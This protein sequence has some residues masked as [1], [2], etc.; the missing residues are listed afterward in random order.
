MLKKMWN[1]IRSRI[2]NRNYEN[3]SRLDQPNGFV[4][5]QAILN[6]FR[7]GL[8][9]MNKVG[10]GI[11]AAYNM[12]RLTGQPT[13]MSELILEF[14]TNLTETIPFGFFGINPFSMKKFF[15]A[16]NISYCI[17]SG[18]NIEKCREEGGV[19]IFAFWIDAKNPFKGAHYV[20][21]HF[22]NG[23][24]EVYNLYNN[25]TGIRERVTVSEII[26]DGRL[27]RGF[28]ITSNEDDE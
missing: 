5:G 7:F 27:I 21:A 23:K 11:V 26:G 22:R 12:L 9:T 16:H 8:T 2:G 19:Y 18:D 17:L 20:T 15:T 13:A 10:C 25:S 24:F 4:F 28:L 1:S 3:N 6:Q 14:E